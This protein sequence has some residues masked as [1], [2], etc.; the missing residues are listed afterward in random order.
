M[1]DGWRRLFARPCITRPSTEMKAAPEGARL[2]VLRTDGRNAR[3][4][5]EAKALFCFCALV[6]RS[7]LLLSSLLMKEGG[8]EICRPLRNSRVGMARAFL[9]VCVWEAEGV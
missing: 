4:L 9:R 6:L 7:H 2:L 3:A 8:G 5:C 1:R